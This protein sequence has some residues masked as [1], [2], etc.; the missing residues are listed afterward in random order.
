MT[1]ESKGPIVLLAEDSEDDAFF[2]RWTLKKAGLKCELVHAPDGLHAVRILEKCIGPD[3]KRLPHSP[4]LVFLDLKMP[5]LT[6]FEV[7]E[8]LRSHPFVPALDVSVLSGS[9]HASDIER[10]KSL[11]AS[12]YFVKPISAE[13]LRGRFE[14]LNERRSESN[15]SNSSA[16]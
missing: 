14:A 10:A 9:E 16:A 7:L 12:A 13:N 15:A 11:G 8:W 1:A 3:G 4:D 5:A 6:G 2:F